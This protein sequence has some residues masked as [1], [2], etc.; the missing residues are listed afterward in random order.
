MQI[1]T[2]VY[3]IK[4]LYDSSDKIGVAILT[5]PNGSTRMDLKGLG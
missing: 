4:S 3:S 5:R 1:N 2:R